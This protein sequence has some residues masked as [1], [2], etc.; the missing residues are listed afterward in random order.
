MENNHLSYTGGIYDAILENYLEAE[1]QK[2]LEKA[3]IKGKHFARQNR[4]ELKGDSLESYTSDSV[5]GHNRLIAHVNQ[6][7]QAESSKAEAQML[8][9][10]ADEKAKERTEKRKTIQ[11]ETQNFELE[12]SENGES[13]HQI[14]SV[15]KSKN[16][17]VIIAFIGLTEIA[18]NVGALQL[19]GGNWLT[20]L[21]MSIGITGALFLLAKQLAKYLKESSHDG[22]KKKLVSIGATLLALGVFYMLATLRAERLKDVAHYNIHP[23]WLVFLNLVF[24]IVTVWYIYKNTVPASE[25]EEHEKNLREKEHYENLKQQDRELEAEIKAIKDELN[26]KLNMLLYKPEYA[27]HLT[28]RIRRWSAEAVEAFKSSN[29]THRHDRK[30]P[31]CFL[32]NKARP[33]DN[34][35]TI[36]F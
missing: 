36:N 10:L 23:I 14:R 3:R 20:A 30:T 21:I 17:N 16:F 11:A 34:I 29:L 19:L 6:K 35:H 1:H 31:D 33:F 28:E 25:K 7:L 5:A 15:Q 22:M 9:A 12:K 32:S 8:I 18:I 2:L 24:Y 26:Q 27:K 4:P 13:M